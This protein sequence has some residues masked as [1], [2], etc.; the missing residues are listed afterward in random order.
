MADKKKYASAEFPEGLKRTEAFGN[1]PY[2]NTR[3]D[4]ADD[5]NA[6]FEQVAEVPMKNG[7]DN[8]GTPDQPRGYIPEYDGHT[9]KDADHGPRSFFETMQ[10]RRPKT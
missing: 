7:E 1:P 3:P 5:F 10:A 2:Q 6:Q 4:L 8:E 9:R